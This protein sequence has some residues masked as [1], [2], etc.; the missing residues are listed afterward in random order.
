MSDIEDNKQLTKS[1][2]NVDKDYKKSREVLGK[3]VDNGMA[4]LEDLSAV[5]KDSEHPRAY[6][7]YSTM[8]KNIA[9]V[10]E[11]L[12]D[13]NKKYKEVK[14]DN[15]NKNDGVSSDGQDPVGVAAF[16]GTT[17]DLQKLLNQQKNDE[18][19]IDG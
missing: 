14:Q 16:I 10:N 4:V 9:D 12:I 13:L 3:L 5:V 11:K 2:E 19:V 6:E 15:T 8:M 17:A 7:V 1:S 18:K